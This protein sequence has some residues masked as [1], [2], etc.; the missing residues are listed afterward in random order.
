MNFILQDSATKVTPSCNRWPACLFPV[1]V[2]H[3]LFIQFSI[4][5]FINKPTQWSTHV[6]HAIFFKL[7]AVQVFEIIIRMALFI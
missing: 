4:Y 3:L 2:L 1:G 6:H 5:V 7:A